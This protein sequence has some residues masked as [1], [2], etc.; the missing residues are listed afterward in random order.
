MGRGA[1]GDP[2]QAPLTPGT[3]TLSTHSLGSCKTSPRTMM[4]WPGQRPRG[5]PREQGSSCRNM[6]D[7]SD[8][9]GGLK[10]EPS[11]RSGQAGFLLSTTTPLAAPWTLAVATSQ[12]VS[13]P[14]VTGTALGTNVERRPGRPGDPA[15]SCPALPGRGA[16]E[17]RLFPD[18]ASVSTPSH[19]SS[20]PGMWTRLQTSWG[21]KGCTHQPATCQQERLSGN[22]QEAAWCLLREGAACYECYTLG[23]WA[24]PSQ[25]HGSPCSPLGSS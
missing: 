15:R 17:P 23:Y 10:G 24:C 2:D 14:P 6:E 9:W 1:R 3:T 7:D 18:T 5:R 20:H 8:T 19:P 4:T 13:S 16:L 11:P 21:L 12:S 22:N 25:Q